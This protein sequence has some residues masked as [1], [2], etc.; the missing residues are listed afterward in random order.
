MD[1]QRI[2]TE[3]LCR[4]MAERQLTQSVLAELCFGLE[5]RDG[6]WV[7]RN[8]D[9]ICAYC[10]GKAYP[11]RVNLDLLAEV[12]GVKPD[13]LTEPAEPEPI[14][15][16]SIDDELPVDAAMEILRIMTEHRQRVRSLRRDQAPPGKPPQDL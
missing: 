10:N 3:N 8:R 7:A 16:L 11:K 6:Y 15:R 13:E 5:L 4:L 2:F 12:L 9:R 14:M 1:R